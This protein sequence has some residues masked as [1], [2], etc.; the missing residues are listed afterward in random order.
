VNG[1]DVCGEI[2]GREAAEDLKGDSDLKQVQVAHVI[3]LAMNIKTVDS[4]T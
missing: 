2:K 3:S 1:A 4:S